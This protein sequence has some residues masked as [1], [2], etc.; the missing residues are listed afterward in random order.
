MEEERQKKIFLM[1]VG[2]VF[3]IV[4]I[5]VLWIFNL[6]NVWQINKANSSVTTSSNWAELRADF[7]QLSID[8]NKRIAKINAD[9]KTTGADDLVASASPD[10]LA[11][12]TLVQELIANTN[13]LVSSSTLLA[14]SSVILS[15]PDF[16]GSTTFS[17]GSTTATTTNINSNC[18]KYINCMP[19]VDEV[20]PCQI[21]VGCE[22]ITIIAY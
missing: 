14:T 18:P 16:I 8:L 7:D 9:R 19:L 3:F 4:L 5:F 12:N 17:V 11:A 2:V 10:V 20:R 15:D 22:G 13:N 21:P 1:K 6:Q